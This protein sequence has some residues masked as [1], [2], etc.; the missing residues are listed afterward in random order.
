[1]RFLGTAK[2]LVL[3]STLLST[4]VVRADDEPDVT[5]EHCEVITESPLPDDDHFF[6]FHQVHKCFPSFFVLFQFT[7]TLT[8]WFIIYVN[9]A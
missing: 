9:L 8:F 6:N 4:N 1:M 3:L 7:L 5:E 2:S